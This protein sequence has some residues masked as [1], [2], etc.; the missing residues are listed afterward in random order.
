MNSIVTPFKVGLLVLIAVA[1]F[2]AFQMALK[3]D[4]ADAQKIQ[5]VAYFDDASGLGVKSRIQTAGIPVGEVVDIRLEGTRARLTLAI[6]DDVQLKTDA[7]LLKRSESMLGDYLIDLM[8]GSPDAP[9]MPPGGTIGQVIDHTG[10]DEAMKHLNDIAAD[11]KEVTRSL[12]EVFGNEDGANNMRAIVDN[13]VSVSSSIDKTLKESGGTLNSAL[14][15]IDALTR[16]ISRLTKN[17]GDNVEAIVVNIRDVSEQARELLAQVRGLL[18]KG[19]GELTNSIKNLQ[20]TMAKLDSAIENVDSITRKIDEGDGPIGRLINDEELGERMSETLSDVSDYIGRAVGM[21]AEVSLRSEYLFRQESVKN[22]FGIKLIP[23]PDK[24]YLIELIDDPRGKVTE[25]TVR[26]Y[27]PAEG[28]EELQTILT[29]EQSF[30]I[31]AQFAKR[32]YF[33]TL[34]FGIIESTGGIGGN[35]HFFD[36]RLAFTVDMFDFTARDVDWPRLRA[37]LSYSFLKHL[38]VNVGVDDILNS[39]RSLDGYEVQDGSKLNTRKV[40]RGRDW[41][42]GA[43]FYFTDEDF[44]SLLSAIPTP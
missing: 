40:V 15:N 5:V 6:R 2:T 38:T 29:T 9:P 8:P 44:K 4:A 34:R 7:K 28:E 1:A 3:T 23:K 21:A 42:V 24:Y 32:F 30:K 12:R 13:L 39:P 18:G 11:I 17:Q 41:F 35:L 10:M 31:S 27:P 33:A 19:E 14:T 16:D 37:S 26:R 20:Q 43:G 22:T 25:T 36:D